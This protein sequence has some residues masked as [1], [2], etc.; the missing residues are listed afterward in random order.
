MAVLKGSSKVTSRGQV[1]IPQ[2]IREK[3]EIKTGDTVYFLIENEKIMIQKGP[4]QI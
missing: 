1:T 3:F 4:I 2:E